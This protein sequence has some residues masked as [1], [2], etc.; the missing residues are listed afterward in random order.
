[1][2]KISEGFEQEVIHRNEGNPYITTLPE[3]GKH[4]TEII[5]LVEQYLSLG[6]W[7]NIKIWIALREFV[8]CEGK[9]CNSR[10]LCGFGVCI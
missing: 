7:M 9:F 2:K 10:L 4:H 8:I 1:M 3:N 5:Q 6:K